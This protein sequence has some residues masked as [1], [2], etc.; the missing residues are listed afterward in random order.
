MRPHWRVYH[1][2]TCEGSCFWRQCA[3]GPLQRAAGGG[4]ILAS[5]PFSLENYA[6][7]D[8]ESACNPLATSKIMVA[9]LSSHGLLTA[10][11]VSAAVAAA[12]DGY[13]VSH[14]TANAPASV[15]RSARSWCKD[16]LAA[17]G[18][19]LLRIEISRTELFFAARS[20][21]PWA[22]VPACPPRVLAAIGDPRHAPCV[23]CWFLLIFPCHH[24]G[25]HQFHVR[26]AP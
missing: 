19:A 2:Y 8:H 25:P 22:H 1:R 6:K 12:A 16:Q 5:E 3:A 4:K 11:A 10:P 26:L 13:S 21:V 7:V 17:A 14:F 18:G 20:A 9:W 23:C 24:S 15:T